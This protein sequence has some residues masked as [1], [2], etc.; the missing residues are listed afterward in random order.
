M[1]IN[2][3]DTTPAAPAGS[4]NIKWQTDGSGNISGNVSTVPGGTKQTVAPVAGVVTA[5]VSLGSSIFIN[6]NAVI[7]NIVL[8]NP[9]DGQEITILFAQDVTGHAVTLGTNM[10]GA[11]T[12]TT[13]ANKHSCYS[14]TYNLADTNWYLLGANNM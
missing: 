8:S 14:W 4:F 2:Y 7:T 13:T 11:P 10:L 5:D 12:I 9:I 6:I 1:S 3:S